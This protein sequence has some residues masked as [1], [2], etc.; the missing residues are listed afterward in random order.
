MAK[1]SAISQIRGSGDLEDQR[2]R[3]LSF[4]DEIHP[5]VIKDKDYWLKTQDEG[6]KIPGVSAKDW[7]REI[8]DKLNVPTDQMYEEKLRVYG[9]ANG[10]FLINQYWISGAVIIF[11]KRFYMWGVAE[12]EEI[13]PHT[14]EILNYVKPRPDYFIIGTGSEP[15]SFHPAFLEHFQKMG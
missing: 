3:V 10:Q 15:Y 13:R 9:L 12:P 4:G 7:K 11:P 1:K 8:W 5:A 2:K 14:L 6:E